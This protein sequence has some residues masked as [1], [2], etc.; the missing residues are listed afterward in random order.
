MVGA[1]NCGICTSTLLADEKL[2]RCLHCAAFLCEECTG[3]GFQ[4]CRKCSVVLAA[5][6][7]I[8]QLNSHGRHQC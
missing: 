5:Q 6:L 1:R 7:E 3:E 8:H 4:I 2:S